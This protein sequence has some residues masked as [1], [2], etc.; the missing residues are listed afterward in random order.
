MLELLEENSYHRVGSHCL[1]VKA[2]AHDGCGIQ[3]AVDLAKLLSRS[4]FIKATELGVFVIINDI[5]N[6]NLMI[7]K[8]LLDTDRYQEY[9]DYEIFLNTVVVI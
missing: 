5:T 9:R 6:D 3:T 4:Y 7:I 2:D 8:E 1:F